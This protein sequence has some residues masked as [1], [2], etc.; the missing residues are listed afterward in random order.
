M[1]RL[2]VS[3][4]LLLASALTA[5][6]LL[7]LLLTSLTWQQFAKP[8]LLTLRTGDRQST[9]D[10]AIHISATVGTSR[11]TCAT[12]TVVT[13]TAGTEVVFCYVVTNTGDITLTNHFVSDPAANIRHSITDRT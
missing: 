2:L 12:T 1:R 10:A 3:L 4:G 9:T 5:L 7:I 13:V 11:Q 6:F 8:T